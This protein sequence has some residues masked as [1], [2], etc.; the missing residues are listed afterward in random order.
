VGFLVITIFETWG[1]V[2]RMF[3]LFIWLGFT[4]NSDWLSFETDEVTGVSGNVTL[5]GFDTNWDELG[6]GI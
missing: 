5:S 3:G 1:G 4:I 2:T 6:S